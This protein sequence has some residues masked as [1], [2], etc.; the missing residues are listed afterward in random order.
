M[1]DDAT[2]A[3]IQVLN[4]YIEN[5]QSQFPTDEFAALEEFLNHDDEHKVITHR[6]LGAVDEALAMWYKRE[7]QKPAS[8]VRWFNKKKDGPNARHFSI[9][10]R[11]VDA[12]PSTGIYIWLHN[13]KKRFRYVGQAADLAKRTREHVTGAFVG[14]DVAALSHAIRFTSPDEWQVI[15]IP[16]DY[17]PDFC[18]N[19]DDRET[20]ATLFEDT[21]WPSGLN[22]HVNVRYRNVFWQ[23]AMAYLTRMTLPGLPT[24]KKTITE[25]Y[26]APG[27]LSP[28]HSAGGV[29]LSSPRS[30]SAPAAPAAPVTDATSTTTPLAGN[31]VRKSSAD[32]LQTTSPRTSASQATSTLSKPVRKGSAEKLSSPR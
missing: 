17:F 1:N 10:P 9:S 15:E 26:R 30:I 25:I 14:A 20:F 31:I 2:E 4:Q 19:I 28:R 13:T 18:T 24:A 16:V 23:S 8:S 6:A 27:T 22:R 29:A 11:L 7:Q 5:D 3:A 32:K 21:L 12:N